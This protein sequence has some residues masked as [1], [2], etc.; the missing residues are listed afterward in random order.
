MPR[1]ATTRRRLPPGQRREELLSVAAGLVLRDGLE[2]LTLEAVAAAA[3]C[4]RGLAYTYFPNRDEL[5]EA[6]LDEEQQRL[7]R[8]V[9]EAIPRPA[10]LQEWTDAW[11]R[12]VFD[13]AEERGPLLFALFRRQLRASPGDTLGPGVI[14]RLAGM[15]LRSDLALSRETA[16]A[17]AG[18]VVWSL[19][20][21]IVSMQLGVS[22]DEAERVYR[23]SIGATL[24]AIG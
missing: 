13:A 3:G 2:S 21:A 5:V 17:L 19:V 6:L 4:S 15:R 18:V 7:S 12:L 20:G 9:L 14:V 10:T 23:L 11:A 1:P 24:R 22:R 8:R 16:V